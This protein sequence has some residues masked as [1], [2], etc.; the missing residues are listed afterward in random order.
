M[1]FRQSMTTFGDRVLDKALGTVEAGAC[2]PEA[3]QLCACWIAYPCSRLGY[4][5]VVEYACHGSCNVV[6]QNFCC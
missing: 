3:G 4:L 6:N 2:V 1:T 5:E